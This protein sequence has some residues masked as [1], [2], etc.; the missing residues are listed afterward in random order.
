MTANLGNRPESF[1]NGERGTGL[2]IFQR[3]VGYVASDRRGGGGRRQWLALFVRIS[4][5][6]PATRRGITRLLL[7]RSKL[8][9]LG[10][11]PI[12]AMAWRVQAYS[13]NQS[14]PLKV[15]YSCSSITWFVRS[16]SFGVGWGL[17]LV[18]FLTFSAKTCASSHKLCQICSHLSPVK[19]QRPH[20]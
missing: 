5:R 19:L 11:A 2:G 10:H 7:I 1:D 17:A 8:L 18:K 6:D 13:V 12:V 16:L 20:G 14:Q 3:Q 4:R 15:N 9:L